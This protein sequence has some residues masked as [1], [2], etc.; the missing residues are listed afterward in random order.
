MYKEELESESDLD[1]YSYSDSYSELCICKICNKNYSS[2]MSLYNHNKTFHSTEDDIIK[3]K[4]KLEK[5]EDEN[6]KLQIK[7]QKIKLNMKKNKIME[8]SKIAKLK[9]EINTLKMDIELNNTKIK[10]EKIK[11]EKVKKINNTNKNEDNKQS[12]DIPEEI[13]INKKETKETN[14]IKTTKYFKDNYV[15][16]E[17]QAISNK[18]N[19]SFNLSLKDK[20]LDFDDSFSEKAIE[21]ANFTKEEL[22][23]IFST[24]Q[25]CQQFHEIYDNFLRLYFSKTLFNNIFVPTL[26]SKIVYKYSNTYYCFLYSKLKDSEIDQEYFDK[27][28]EALKKIYNNLIKEELIVKNDKIETFFNTLTISKCV[29]NNG[30]QYKNM[31]TFKRDILKMIIYENKSNII[32]SSEKKNYTTF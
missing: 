32:T 6:I 8:Q 28:I 10:T 2:R 16:S 18:K 24:L 1:S 30:R 29:I 31:K 25:T 12:S 15:L 26:N 9:E 19:G 5:M 14:N 4:K 7:M 13:E 17:G 22:L 11:E 21:M 3:L 27:S 20:I 23:S